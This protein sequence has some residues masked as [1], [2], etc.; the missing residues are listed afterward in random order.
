MVVW[1]SKESISLDVKIIW[2]M[3]IVHEA[4]KPSLA[5]IL[6]GFV[7]GTNRLV[8]THFRNLGFNPWISPALWFA[9]SSNMGTHATNLNFN[10]Q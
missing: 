10:L 1:I 7:I 4:W 6:N 9:K 2:M 8:T 3:L 5:I